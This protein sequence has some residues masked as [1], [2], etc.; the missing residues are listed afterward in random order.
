MLNGHPEII[1]PPESGFLHW[2]H[3]KYQNWSASNNNFS[4]VDLFVSDLMQS[5]KIEGLSLDYEKLKAMILNTKP[6]DYSCLM[7][8]VYRHYAELKGKNPSI[9]ADK[10]NYYINHLDD[11]SLIWPDAF[12]IMVV[13]DGR[14]VACSYLKIKTLDTNSKYKPVLT[15][16]IGLIADEWKKNNEKMLNFIEGKKHLIIR[17][18]DLVENP[19]SELTKVCLFLGITY[20]DSMIRYHEIGAT[21]HD[22]PASTI[23]WKKKTLEKPDPMNVGKYKTEL[24]EDS[25]NQF[26]KIAG[27]TLRQFNYVI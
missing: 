4:D 9:I 26:N 27:N 16:D 10:N 24:N 13:R 1:S 5:K 18:E 20:D 15:T 17:Y 2:W 22:E 21:Q 7:T 11:L 14:D 19:V 25:I 3:K 8:L 6:L 12:Y 23:D